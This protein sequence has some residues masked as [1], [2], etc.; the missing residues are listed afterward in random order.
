[1]LVG[2]G[3]EEGAL[4]RLAE[5]LGIQTHVIFAGPQDHVEQFL[6]IMDV[7]VSSSLWEGL[8]TVI[9]EAIMSGVPV[10]A[11]AVAGTV[12]VVKHGETGFL[13]E[14]GDPRALALAILA[15]L[16]QPP[17]PAMRQRAQNSVKATFSIASVAIQAEQ[18]Y[19]RLLKQK[20][21]DELVPR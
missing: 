21:Y 17:T 19:I 1:M 8:P 4:K 13:V 7:F 5:A 15:M 14:P 18:L 12:E 9:L 11:T 3:E 2:G 10:V 6:A 20:G 16:S